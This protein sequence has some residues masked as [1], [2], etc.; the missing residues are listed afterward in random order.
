MSDNLSCVPAR[1][2]EISPSAN[3]YYVNRYVRSY[4]CQMVRQ[5]IGNDGRH[6]RE[7][8]ALCE[9]MISAGQQ[10]QMFLDPEAFIQSAAL[11]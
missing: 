2:A 5:P 4:S 8:L 11:M 1:T 3:R 9:L 10:F 7:I 6:P